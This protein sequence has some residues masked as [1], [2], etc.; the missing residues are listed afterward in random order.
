[1][2][3]FLEDNEATP[4]LQAK[5]IRGGLLSIASGGFNSVV[6]IG[7]TLLLA[8]MLA[9]EDFGLVAMVTVIVGFAPVLIDLGTRD[10]VVQKP[11]VTQQDISSLFW[12]IT[13]VGGVCTIALVVA[14]PWLANFYR[15]PRVAQIVLVSSLTFLL[16]ALACQHEALLRRSM[17]FRE[18]ASVESVA[19]IGASALA[20]AFALFGGGFWALVARPVLLAALRMAG[21]WWLCG[22]RPGPPGWT[23]GM[24]EMLRFGLMLSGW[25]LLDFVARSADRVAIGAGFGARELGF[26]QNAFLVYDNSLNLI[27]VAFHGVAVASLSKVRGSVEQLQRSW[28]KAIGT[29]TFFSMPAFAILAVVGHDLLAVLLGAKWVPAGLLLTILALRGVPHVVERAIGSLHVAAGRADRWIWWGVLSTSAHLAAL[30]VGLRYGTVGVVVAYVVCMHAIVFVALRFSSKLLDTSM[31]VQ[32]QP[33]APQFVSALACAGGGFVVRAMLW[34]GLSPWAR[35]PIEALTCVV[36]YL[37]LMV[38]AFKVTHPLGF[39][40]AAEL[41]SFVSRIPGVRRLMAPPA[42]AGGQGL[43]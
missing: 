39:L 23:R 37:T 9:P 32:V 28:A 27:A 29:V 2:T 5:S 35:L 38:G 31:W 40:R 30:A 8:R 36:I 34:D 22:W 4:R 13:L 3:K 12:F 1:L 14:G 42:S 26:Y 15:E 6:Q 21:L 10:A 43:P 7:T 11:S 16:T 25:C 17:M 19:N 41:E 24:S 33:I 20:L 18:M